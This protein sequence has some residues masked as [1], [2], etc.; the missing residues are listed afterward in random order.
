MATWFEPISFVFV[1]CS[2]ADPDFW[3]GEGESKS[4]HPVEEH[5]WSDFH[6]PG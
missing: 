6:S 2:G 3:K 4:E 5:T 1:K